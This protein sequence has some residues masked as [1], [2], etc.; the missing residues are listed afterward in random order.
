MQKIHKRKKLVT[1]LLVLALSIIQIPVTVQAAST[2]SADVSKAGS[3]NILVGVS[4]SFEKVSKSKILKRINQIRK[5]ACTKG[6]INP[7]TGKKLK[8]SD[9]VAIKW[10]SNLEWIALLRAAECTVNEGHT[11]PNGKSC[12][13]ISYKNEQSWAENLAWNYSG[14][15]EGIEQWYREKDDWVKQNSNAVTGHYTSLINP[16]YKYIGLGSFVRDSGGWYGVSAEFGYHTNGA[17]KQSSVK[18]KTVQTI[19][20]A[21]KN[22]KQVKLNAPSSIKLKKTKALTVSCEV[23][24]PGIMGGVNTTKANIL[25]GITWKS[26][27]PSVISVKSNGKITAKKTGKAVISAKI[28]GV[29]TV[30]KTITVKK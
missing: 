6:Y 13:S 17:Q 2:R 3:D 20:V 24:Y 23:T 11:R 8:A 9:Y 19:E 14:L 1:V 26:S 15:M 5:E 16:A 4:G 7:S 27:K 30:K 29:K 28:K 12:F 18:G 22:I 25:D 21:K 10:S